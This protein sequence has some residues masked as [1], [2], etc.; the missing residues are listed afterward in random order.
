MTENKKNIGWVLGECLGG[1]KTFLMDC[2]YNL[3]K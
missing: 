2:C 3:G 1:S